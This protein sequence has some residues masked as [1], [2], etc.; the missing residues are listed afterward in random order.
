MLL[1]R[2]DDEATDWCSQI[3]NPHTH[4]GVGFLSLAKLMHFLEFPVQGGGAIP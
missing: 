4:D 3:E 1:I 2:R